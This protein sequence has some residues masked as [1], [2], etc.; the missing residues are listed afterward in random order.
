[1]KTA[2][3]VLDGMGLSADPVGNAV[4]ADSMPFMFSAMKQNGYASLAASG[5]AVGLRENIVGNSEVGHLTIGAGTKVPSTLSRMDSAYENSSWKNNPLWQEFASS[6][7]CHIVGLLSDAGVH[8]HLDTLWR[9]AELAVAKGCSQVVVH[10]VLDGVD[11]T[12]RSAPKLLRFLVKKLASLPE[13]KLGMVIGRK[14]FC[15]RS[16]ATEP[17]ERLVDAFKNIEK[18]PRFDPECLNGLENE[19]DFPPHGHPGVIGAQPGE[20]VF[21][22]SH[23]GD[24]AV[25]VAR[26]M[27]RDFDVFAPILLSN[28]VSR[29]RA[30]FPFVPL[31]QGL[32]LELANAGMKTLRIA[33][34]CKFPH[35]TSFFNGLNETIA[36][37]SLSIPT[38]AEADLP[39]K[40]EMSVDAVVDAGIRGIEAGESDLIVMNIANLDQ[41]GHLGKLDLAI[42]AARKV[43]AAA[44]RLCAAARANDWTVI[45]VADH[46]NAD[47]VETPDGQPFGSHTDR[48]VP[49][50]VIPSPAMRGV[51]LQQQGS[52]ANVAATVLASMR[53]TPPDY[54][55]PSLLDFP[56]QYAEAL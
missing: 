26:A 48:P 6:Q 38:P 20:P 43:D 47:R 14:S 19:R 55:Q 40:P 42:V 44:K 22:T 30:F 46:G 5:P 8:G 17:A 10:P 27:A 18:L 9:G 50:I 32:A 53:R 21:L 37:Q 13:V 41:I 35:V 52:L 23:R 7:R 1:M 56:P 25:Q 3:I 36:S 29:E 31:N 12:A 54:M 28:A 34:D 45:F 24:R 16:G 51:W 49:L 33:E 15:D 11:S 4:T 39:Q 2:L